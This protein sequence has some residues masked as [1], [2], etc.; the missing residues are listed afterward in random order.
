VLGFETI[1]NATIIA[2]DGN[3]ILATDPWINGDAYFG[4]WGLS[5]EVPPEQLAAI[6]ACKY[7]W[8][9]H[10]QFELVVDHRSQRQGN[11]PS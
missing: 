4:S 3:P 6:K 7:Y 8:I 5:H 9:S 2:Y 11:S 1:G 10:G